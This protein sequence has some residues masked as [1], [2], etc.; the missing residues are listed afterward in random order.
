MNPSALVRLALVA[1]VMPVAPRVFAAEDALRPIAYQNGVNQDALGAETAEL[2]R[3][4]NAL[5]DELQRNGFPPQSLAGL[6]DL[7]AQL[8]ALGAADMSA[9]ATRLRG[10]GEN[11]KTD[12]R[13]TVSEV[14]VAQQAIETRLKALAQQ[15][16]LRQLREEAVHRLEALIARQLAAQ[17]ETQALASVRSPGPRQ[18]L[19]E[20]DQSGVSEDLD[21]FFQT[22]E[23][24]LT[25]LQARITGTAAA[26]AAPAPASGFAER[27]NATALSAFSSEALEQ[28]KGR[29]YAEASARQEALLV[30]LKKLLQGMLSSLPKDQRLASALQQV[31]ALR[32]QETARQENGQKP[33]AQADQAAADR[34]QLLAA[35][36]APVN[37]EAAADLANAQKA[38]QSSAT[39]GAPATPAPATP[40]T[41]GS[42]PP[43]T[44]SSTAPATASASPPTPPASAAKPSGTSGA[45]PP[46]AS[47]SSPSSP[48]DPSKSAAARADALAALTRAEAALRQQLASTQA[49]QPPGS[50]TGSPDASSQ[51]PMPG[52]RPP[53]NS[54]S[55]GGQTTVANHGD[56][57]GGPAQVVGALQHDD[58]EAM[59]TLQQERYPAEYSAWVRQY[60]RNLAKEP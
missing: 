27:V 56:L 53:Q 21:G 17:R 44:P 8:G 49:E 31:A 34:A 1:G 39:K 45:T 35:Q 19:L 29:H 43:A 55:G 37:P 12:S 60:W 52:N 5:I 20:S 24:L 23:T 26:P 6:N 41:P 59:L 2:A 42:K 9:I 40:A 47:P 3:S 33:D 25:R 58:R 4:I 54:S 28:I 30:E 57:T 22:G 7:V 50:A 18:S 46:P 13:G 16:A 15:I 38:L 51:P 32:Q 14:Y 36:I 10:L 11:T 48:S